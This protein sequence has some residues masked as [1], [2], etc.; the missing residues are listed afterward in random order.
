M[1]GPR[2]GSTRLER[3]RSLEDLDILEGEGVFSWLH[4]TGDGRDLGVP[5]DVPYRIGL[6]KP[7][8]FEV[9]EKCADRITLRYDRVDPNPHRQ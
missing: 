2:G 8:S 1:S 5:L 7:S 6:A 9:C 3:G 4:G